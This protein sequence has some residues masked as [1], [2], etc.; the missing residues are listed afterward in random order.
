MITQ[1]EDENNALIQEQL[2]ENLEKLSN[3]K[4]ITPEGQVLFSTH[5]I[6]L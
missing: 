6:S 2:L 1:H 3:I 4:P 5:L